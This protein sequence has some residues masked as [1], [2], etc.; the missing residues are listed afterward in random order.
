MKRKI[1]AFSFMTVLVVTL[2]LL[3]TSGTA[4]AVRS[5]LTDFNSTY[6]KAYDCSLCHAS[7]TSGTSPRNSFANAWSGS[8]GNYEI[9]IN[10]VLAAAD[11]DGDGAT[12]AAELSAGTYPGN[13]SSVPATA[14]TTAPTVSITTPATN[15]SVSS[16]PISF[17][18]TASDNVSV[19]QVSWSN[20][21]GGSGTATGTTSWSASIALAS[22]ANLI[23]ITAQDRAGNIA[24]S[25]RTV[26]Y[27]PPD[28]TA[29]TVSI[30]TPAT[31]T[32]VSS[33]PI[34]FSGTASDN[35]SVTQVSWSNSLGGSGTAT[36]TSSWSASIALASGANLITITVQDRAGNIATSTRTVTYT[37]PDVTAP[38]VSITTPAAN[39]SVSSTPISFSGT[40]S[41]NVSVTQVSWSNSL[42]GSGT[43]TGTSSWSASIALASGANLITITVQDRAG[44]IATS[45]RTVTY[46]PPDVTAPTVSITTPAA[47]TSVSSTPISFSGTASD[48]I[49][50]TQVSWS[51]SLGGSG[52]A[53]GTTSWSASIA[54]ASGANLITITVQDRAGNIATATRTVTY[55]PPDVTAP[56][57][58]ITTPAAN[59]SVSSTPISFSG[60]ASDNVSVTQ[61]SWSNSLGGGGTAT[62]TASWSASIALASGANLITITAQ[63]GAGNIATATR[64]VTY[65]LPD[66]TAPTV[67][68]TT[69]AANTSVSSTPISFS[70]TASDT[71]GV[72]QVSWANS[73]RR[74]LEPRQE[75]P[76]GAQASPSSS[77]ANLITVTARD[78]A[79]NTATAIRTVTYTPIIPL[80]DTTPPAVT[81]FSI[82]PTSTSLTVPI[83]SLV[84]TDNVTVAGVMVTESAT[85]P[86]ASSASWGAAPA[87]YT[88]AS[89]SVHTLYA[90]AKDGAGNVSAGRSA[91]TSIT[92]TP[93]DPA[94]TT[95]PTFTNPT[96]VTNAYLPL[97]TFRRNA[98]R[99]TIGRESVRVE[100]R[101]KDSRKEFTVGD[102]T[103][104]TLILEDRT[105][106]S[107]D[108][109]G[110]SV[111]LHCS[112]R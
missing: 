93:P 89:A 110:G 6:G 23:T 4:F 102:K 66:V 41:D 36:G 56:T 91:T 63:D 30:T 80:P 88:F 95:L 21:L 34:S 27:T 10:S 48:N 65:T 97:V 106:V 24:T 29:P 67:S 87:S 45:T 104:S 105:F 46:T 11:S 42:G 39:T 73:T 5:Y 112:S 75:Q 60:T 98:L 72:T 86:A 37:P 96:R 82:P 69:P 54:L 16:T 12:N 15:T 71:V 74:Q 111:E 49:S 40:A 83:I 90:W 20:S 9:P 7:A 76:P 25:T 32:S 101:L 26:T 38:T 92:L 108:L 107:W 51:N 35:V 18:G 58:S 59:T 14:D 50:V 94:A 33:T 31:N 8:I 68:I 78:A 79:G 47:N 3:S 100:R 52:T 64:T 109:R 43:A 22:G 19:T 84:A 85:A 81:S 70:G 1:V 77:G 28:V 2:A 61:V 57:V 62:G 44:N 103:V 55:T 17:S 53:T 99:G 13:A